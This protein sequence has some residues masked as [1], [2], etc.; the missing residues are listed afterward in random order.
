[1]ISFRY[2]IVSITAVFLALGLGVAVGSAVHPTTALTRE[3]ITRMSSDLNDAR[4]EIAALRAQVQG[5]SAAIKNLATRVNR[6]ALVGRRV[7]YV[8]DG[9]EGAWEGGVRRAMADATAQDVGTITL[10]DRW[11]SAEAPGELRGVA[12]GTGV[13]ISG[14]DIG[15]SLMSAVGDRVGKPEGV[16]LIDALVKAGYLRTDSKT[17]A[18]W[19]PAGATVVAFTSGASDAPEAGAMAAF[20]AAAAKS[21]AVVVLGSAPNQAGAVGA[22]RLQRGLPPRLATFDSGSTDFTGVAPVL[23]LS[24]AIDAHGGH[25][26][27]APGLSYLPRT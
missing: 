11:T 12:A 23:A 20:G 22:L 4:A 24:A 19:P 9:G 8:N 14:D 27:T 25:F 10:T 17:P 13:T 18:P 16:S 3:R 7:L 5:S 26:G 21:T 15:S 2:H 6:G 1:L